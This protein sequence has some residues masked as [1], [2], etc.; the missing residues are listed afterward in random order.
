MYLNCLLCFSAIDN[1]GKTAL[2]YCLHPTMRHAKCIDFLLECGADPNT[3]VQHLQIPFA[4]HA[5]SLQDGSGTPILCAACQSG[6]QRIVERILDRGADP[7][8][9][10]RVIDSCIWLRICV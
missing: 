5:F 6:L 3:M 1:E 4:N 2:F 8:A 7:N 9:K 10:E